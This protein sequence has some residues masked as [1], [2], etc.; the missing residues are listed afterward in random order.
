MATNRVTGMYSGIDTEGLIS[1]LMEAKKLKVENVKKEQMT[2]KYKQEAWKDL[3]KKIKNLFGTISN[4]KY[5]GSYSKAKTEISD[6]SVATITTSD[7]AMLTTQKMSVEKLA[8][9]AYLTGDEINAGSEKATSGTLLTSID[10]SLKGK[11]ITISVNGGKAKEVTITDKTTLGSLTSDLSNAGVNC[12]F[13]AATQ[14]IFIGATKNGAAGN[15][16]LGGDADALSTLGLDSTKKIEG[17]D[18]AI[19]LNGARFTSAD[20]TYNVNGLTITAKAETG[21]EEVTLTTAK[22]TSAVYDMIKKFITE[23]SELMNEMDKLYNAD[24]KTKYQPLTDEEKAAMSDYEIEQWE[25]KM[26]EQL[27]AKDSDIN[28]VSST[29]KDI[30][31]QGFEVGGKTLYLFNFGIE[32]GGYF[33]TADNEKNAYHIKGDADDNL[34]SSET[35]EL[36]R[37]IESD[38]DAVTGFFTQ[39]TR[40][41][42]DR[43]D[44]MSA[45]VNETRSYGS[46]Y[47]DLRL[48][49]EYSDY[50]SKIADMEDKLMQYEDKWYDKFAAMESAMAKM[51]SNQNA[52][53]GLLGGSN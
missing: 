11:T 16:E 40:T 20:N 17:E 1:Q 24:T 41:L 38:P 52:I 26:K 33:E 35:N 19:I 15:F 23:Y 9:N 37:M 4:L 7:D 49:K 46:F 43:M 36:Q 6:S 22:D 10:P 2:N 32:T 8:T 27:L 53:S 29:L 31:N 21:D 30:M 44:K 48:T 42:Y 12:K 28:S 47:D 45:R 25:T 5:E 13:D 14:R 18:G 3:N 51:Q 50:T 34:Y 39:L